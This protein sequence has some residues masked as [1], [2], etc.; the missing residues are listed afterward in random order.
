MSTAKKNLKKFMQSRWKVHTYNAGTKSP[1]VAHTRADIVTVDGV[2]GPLHLLDPELA[3]MLVD[4]H[5][6]RRGQRG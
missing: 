6:A 3:Q 4:D 2:R 1:P 5:N